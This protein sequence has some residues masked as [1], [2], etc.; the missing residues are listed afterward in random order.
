MSDTQII[1]DETVEQ[2]TQWQRQRSAGHS[3]SAAVPS[4]GFVRFELV[5]NCQGLRSKLLHATTPRSQF[6]GS[7]VVRNAISQYSLSYYFYPLTLFERPSIRDLVLPLWGA[8]AF[9]LVF[10]RGGSCHRPPSR[11]KTTGAGPVGI[12]P[13]L[14]RNGPR[15]PLFSAE[16]RSSWPLNF[17]NTYQPCSAVSTLQHA[18]GLLIIKEVALTLDIGMN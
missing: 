18:P 11:Y 10:H 3:T 17:M 7:P 8:R 9:N 5:R 14:A 4:V 2:L 6:R 12:I 15:C 13:S 16:M 1:R